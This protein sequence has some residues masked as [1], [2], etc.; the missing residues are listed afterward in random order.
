MCKKLHF[1]TI[2]LQI[3]G[4]ELLLVCVTDVS[5]F[6]ASFWLIRNS[7]IFRYIGR[8]VTNENVVLF[9]LRFIFACRFVLYLHACVVEILKFQETEMRTDHKRA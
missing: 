8:L 7:Q 1:T 2:I 9:S 4:V 6:F 5:R 3:F